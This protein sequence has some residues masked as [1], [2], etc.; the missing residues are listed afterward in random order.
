[1]TPFSPV[2]LIPA[3]RARRKRLRTRITGWAIG[4]AV[5]VVGVMVAIG[6]HRSSL[7]PILVPD[8]SAQGARIT[9]LTSE[10]AATNKDLA[11]ARTRRAAILML[12]GRPD[13]SLLLPLLGRSMGDEVVLKELKLTQAKTAGARQYAVEMRGIA[14]TTASASNFVSTLEGTGLFD[15]VRLLRTGREPFLTTSMVSFDLQCKL[16]DSP[17]PAGGGK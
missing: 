12:A 7:R 16:S 11:E 1:M 5:Y 9:Q 3:P 14:R 4:L 17:R 10:L 13:W 8:P 2:N 6:V 15:D